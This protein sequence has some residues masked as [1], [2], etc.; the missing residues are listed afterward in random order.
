MKFLSKLFLLLIIILAV[1]V[2]ANIYQ[3]NDAFANPFVKQSI[4]DK[5]KRSHA[6]MVEDKLEQVGDTAKEKIKQGV[7]NLGDKIKEVAEEL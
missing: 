5:M 4:L 3:D 6:D 1:W 7:N 2:G